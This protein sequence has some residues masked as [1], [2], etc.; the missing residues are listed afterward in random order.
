M[1]LESKGNEI[2]K[3]IYEE[4]KDN[5]EVLNMVASF[6]IIDFIRIPQ[7]LAFLER[8]LRLNPEQQNIQILALRLRR[9][10][11]EKINDPWAGR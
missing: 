8:S 4:N 7:G 11:L 1:G 10:Y 2:I 6:F 5:Y 9:E 3:G